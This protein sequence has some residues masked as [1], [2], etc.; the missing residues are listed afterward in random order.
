MP[1][2]E[3]FCPGT[4]EAARGDTVEDLAG[5]AE[6]QS[7]R[8]PEVL[9]KSSANALAR[10]DPANGA[11]WVCPWSVWMVPAVVSETV[12]EAMRRAAIPNLNEFMASNR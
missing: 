3:A 12:A 1:T 11:E 5:T 2:G 4:A 8:E 6:Q 7:I 10:G 9:F